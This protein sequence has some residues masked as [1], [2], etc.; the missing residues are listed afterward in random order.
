MGFNGMRIHQ[1][2]ESSRLL[3]HADRLGILVWAEL[4]SFYSNDPFNTVNIFNELSE[5]VLKHA[6]HP[7]VITWTP[8]NESWGVN[9]ILT[10]VREQQITIAGREL[11]RALDYEHRPVICNDG[12]EHTLSDILTIHDYNYLKVIFR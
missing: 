3:Y 8:F 1:K 5:L 10:N 6:N 11:I 2:I 9:S 4:P 12:W 7:S